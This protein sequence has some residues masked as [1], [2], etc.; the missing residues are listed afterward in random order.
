MWGSM[1]EPLRTMGRLRAPLPGR[2]LGSRPRGPPQQSHLK[3]P[4]GGEAGSLAL[5]QAPQRSTCFSLLARLSRRCP[6]GAGS[7]IRTNAGGGAGGLG[8]RGSSWTRS[9]PR[10]GLKG[11]RTGAWEEG[12]GAGG[13]GGGRLDRQHPSQ[14]WQ[15]VWE[16][17]RPRWGE[18]LRER[19][20]APQPGR[21]TWL[22]REVPSAGLLCE[23]RGC[24][25][26]RAGREVP[27]RQF[28][29]SQAA[30]LPTLHTPLLPSSF[31]KGDS[32]EK[33]VSL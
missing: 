8:P 4:G 1:P 26:S 14:S 17:G 9:D 5:R 18:V 25:G 24:S 22:S 10:L 19:V 28:L 31:Q 16:A 7:S 33:A 32:A 13:G 3:L 27:S 29:Q 30:F 12:R 21:A 23:R 6:R 20:P 2:V 15:K 11:A